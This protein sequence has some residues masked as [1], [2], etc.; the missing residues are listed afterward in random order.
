MAE[1]P[2]GT[3][4][5]DGLTRA[6]VFAQIVG[7]AAAAEIFQHL[8][9]REVQ[10]LASAIKDLAAIPQSHV[11]AVVGQFIEKV[12][13]HS[14]LG[15]DAERFVRDVLERAHGKEKAAGI[16][17]RITLGGEAQGLEN[18][19]WMDARQVVEIIRD[20]HPQVKAIVLSYLEPDHAA[21]VLELLP[22]RSR[23]DIILRIANL[24][25]V[26][27][28]AL[29]ELNRTLESQVSGSRNVQTAS[30][31]GLK[32]A[33]DVLNFIDTAAE[34]E[35]MEVVKEHDADLGQQIQDLM[36]VFDNLMEVDPGG[37]QALL[38]EVSSDSLLL[39]L[40]GADDELK[41]HFF[42]NMSKRAAEMMR[43]DLDAKGPVR[44]SEVEAAQKE[45]LTIARRLAE[46]GQIALGGSGGEEYI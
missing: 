11:E 19:K 38:R 36:F 25:T 27:P 5:L 32:R 17:D 2:I 13:L 46:D 15:M 9:P 29:K 30:V 22:E 42:G 16:M 35:I 3:Q 37:I 8:D 10:K 14:T 34:A 31:G 33:A 44:V 23:A 43:D 41:E 6:A 39:A 28:A 45:I 20:E 18:L 4:D 21:G 7:E 26:Q 24:D 12:G 40:K 1:D